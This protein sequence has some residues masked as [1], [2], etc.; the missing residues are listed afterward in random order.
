MRPPLRG[1]DAV[2]SGGFVL[3][4]QARSRR[5]GAAPE[6]AKAH[7]GRGGAPERGLLALAKE[8]DGVG[9]GFVGLVALA[10]AQA[11]EA[12]ARGINHAHELFVLR[13]IKCHAR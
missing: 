9:I 11:K 8:R 10:L 12:D 3:A 13:Q 5:A 4:C 2:R 1:A 7:F 6:P